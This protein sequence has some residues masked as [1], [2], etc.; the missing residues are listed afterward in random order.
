MRLENSFLH[1]PGIGEKTE[2]KL[3]KDGVK[4]WDEF[5][6][7]SVLGS[8]K[9]R[10]VENF[11]ETARKNL[12]VGNTQFFANKL[13]N[14]EIWR[15]YRNFE[16]SATFFDIETTGLDQR[17]NRVTTV[18]VYR[19]GD[20]RTYVRGEDLTAENL[21]QE[22]FDSKIV[23]SFNGKRFDQ[24]FLE[25]N[26]DLEVE[27]PHLD[28]MYAC[29]RIGYSGGLK[30]I[31]KELGI[32]RELEDIDGR[33]AVKLWKRYENEGDEDALRKLVR[34]NR[35]DAENLEQLLEAVHE[36]LSEQFFRKHVQ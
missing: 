19:N 1:A 20:S 31:E 33:E 2:Q 15:I 29:K 5:P 13:P 36:R 28:L 25:H 8:T 34:Y 18:S 23:V 9:Q 22:F 16:D 35:Y 10:K 24:P 12:E 3:W 17:K 7:N 14:K 11:L 6:R 4:H 27:T 26:F 32:D 30:A 21:R